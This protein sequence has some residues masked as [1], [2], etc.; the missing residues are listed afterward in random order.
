MKKILMISVAASLMMGVGSC[1]KDSNND[2]SGRIHGGE[3]AGLRVSVQIPRATRADYP[4]Q[5]ASVAESAVKTV[6]VYVF[7][8][9]GN[10]AANGA[11]STFDTT[12]D[13][14]FDTT[15]NEW[16]MTDDADVIN[17]VA[18]DV[19]IWVGLNVPAIMQNEFATESAM[20]AKYNAVSGMWGNGTTTFF[21]MF[22]NAVEKTLVQAGANDYVNDIE[23]SVDRVVTKIIASVA[24]NPPSGIEWGVQWNQSGPGNAEA[25]GIA[26]TPSH[27]RV[28]QYSRSSYVAPHYNVALWNKDQTQ[29]GFAETYKGDL[30]GYGV[31]VSAGSALDF[32][33]TGATNPG[34]VD[35][36][37]E[38][39]GLYIGENASREESGV[40][41]AKNGN[42]TYAF[43]STTVVAT[44]E[45]TWNEGADDSVIEGDEAIKWEVKE[46]G[47]NKASS[48]IWMVKVDGVHYITSTEANALAIKTGLA[49]RDALT[50]GQVI[51]AT[52][53][54][55]NEMTIEDFFTTYPQFDYVE[56]FKFP[57]GY[58]H[59]VTWINKIDQDGVG[60]G[61]PNHYD[62]LRNQFIHLDVT[63]VNTTAMNEGGYF[64]GYPGQDPDKEYDPATGEEVPDGT[65]GAVPGDPKN[66][67]DPTDESNP[68]NPKPLDP[69]DPVDPL[70][71]N[72]KVTVTV[73]PWTYRFNTVTLGK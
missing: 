15:D 44:S 56:I 10:A 16:K 69:L 7:D 6:S 31:A 41:I 4:K 27:W 57:R 37:A 67:T 72:L 47:F 42:T 62:I 46:F 50:A 2:G 39:K 71:A 12:T 33:T 23:V 61:D 34:T 43:I 28:M 17:T 73:N 19:R 26:Y 53:S 14:A 29:T 48:D 65:P 40:Q 35:Y 30:A 25:P 13:F 38:N 18:G 59:F 24:S 52:P 1:T 21:T 8:A 20:L 3:M 66:P 63:G 11:Y 22:S 36:V 5:N 49:V 32:V 45:A 70:P 55:P 68:N 60:G 54:L 9:D 58:V 64:P 51:T